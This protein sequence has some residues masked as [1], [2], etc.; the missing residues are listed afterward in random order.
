MISLSITP[1]E[2][3]ELRYIIQHSEQNIERKRAA[4]ILLK[5][6]AFSHTEIARITEQH[7][8]TITKNVQ[9]YADG[10]LEQLLARGYKSPQGQLEAHKEKLIAYFKENPVTNAKQSVQVIKAQT[11]I[12]LSEEQARRW[13]RKLGMKRLQA[14]H[15]P[16]KADN[17]KQATFK[18]ETLEPLLE[19][20]QNK[21]ISLYFGD[22]V[23]F[24]LQAFLTNFWCFARVWI[25][26]GA[27]RFR[28]SVL[29][30]MNA[31]THELVS[32]MTSGTV[33]AQTVI[34]LLK[35]LHTQGTALPIYLVLDNARYQHCKAV[36][37]M[38]E[39]LGITLVFLPPYSPNLNLIER[40][41]KFMRAKCL[42]GKY[43]D[44]A[45]DFENAIRDTV[46][47]INTD[48]TYKKELQSLLT[49]NFQTFA[50][51]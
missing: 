2:C 37:D 48:E 14:G 24:V 35:L 50:Q 1:K 45:T 38:A 28:F 27:G 10:G 41:W 18:T 5:S 51:N 20:A 16:G 22:G 26:S 4:T 21:E 13:M 44:N 31:V 43:Y 3:N 39:S 36:K 40:L 34:E 33:N 42:S 29:G 49:L 6:K 25:K 9:S 15:I 46:A 8:N 12:L 23:H 17:E 7:P 19:Q 32:V 30:A 47:K 11:G